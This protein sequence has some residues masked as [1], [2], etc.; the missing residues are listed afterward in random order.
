MRQKVI[1]VTLPGSILTILTAASSPVA[2]TRAYRRNRIYP[3]EK[4]KIE[5]KAFGMNL[6]T[7]AFA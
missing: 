5:Y 6:K 7:T 2:T 3:L 4:R 1:I